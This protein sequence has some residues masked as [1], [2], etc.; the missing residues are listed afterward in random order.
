MIHVLKM[1]PSKV[2]VKPTQSSLQKSNR[3]DRQLKYKK[4]HFCH[5]YKLR[6]TSE[7]KSVLPM[8]CLYTWIYRIQ[9][10]TF[11]STF[12]ETNYLSRS[13][14]R[15]SISRTSSCTSCSW[16]WP[17]HKIKCLNLL[18]VKTELLTELNW[19][20]NHLLYFWKQEVTEEVHCFVDW[21]LLQTFPASWFTH[22]KNIA[23][24]VKH[25]S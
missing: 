17:C 5:L 19:K 11:L 15:R 9:V 8:C 16:T 4:Y 14:R 7:T 18:T 22:Y 1:N 20:E 25:V 3:S 13:Q 12:N 23:T 10:T 24:T 21:K 2:Q 6:I